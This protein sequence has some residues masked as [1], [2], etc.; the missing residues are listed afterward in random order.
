[1]LQISKLGCSWRRRRSIIRPSCKSFFL[2]I[3]P[4]F[5]F[6]CSLGWPRP[7]KLLTPPM[8]KFSM[9]AGRTEMC[10]N[11]VPLCKTTWFETDLHDC[12]QLF[13]TT[14]MHTKV[15]QRAPASAVVWG[16]APPQ[17]KVVATFGGHVITATTDK[18]SVWRAKLP[19]TP[20]T[21]TPQTIS[22][23]ASTG[24]TAVLSDVLFGDV[25]VCGGQVCLC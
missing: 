11:W 24:E 13:F 22:F 10:L 9:E 7:P 18:T 23:K 15:L 3:W 16:F 14:V 19:P 8:L 12:C 5:R 25:Y 20:A 4:W 17:T 6:V 2:E 21:K 1:M